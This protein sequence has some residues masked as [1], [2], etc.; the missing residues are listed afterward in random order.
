MA[1]LAY[2]P[3]EKGGVSVVILD[4]DLAYLPREGD[5]HP[6]S[7]H[8]IGTAPFI[9]REVLRG[10]PYKHNLRH[11]LESLMYVLIWYM[12]G[13]RIKEMPQKD[14]LRKWRKGDSSS[15]LEAK[16]LLLCDRPGAASDTIYAALASLQ[17]PLVLNVTNLINKYRKHTYLIGSKEYMSLSDCSDKAAEYAEAKKEINRQNNLSEEAIDDNYVEDWKAEYSRLQSE[18]EQAKELNAN[19]YEMLNYRIWKDAIN[20]HVESRSDCL[21]DCCS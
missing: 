11:D 2:R 19:N 1:N 8:R 20:L 4:H 9:A 16:A 14:P 18:A 3:N 12:F 7:R 5:V 13:Y 6:A 17:S 15:M 10:D 21:E